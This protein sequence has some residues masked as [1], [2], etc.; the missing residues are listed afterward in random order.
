MVNFLFF[1][2]NPPGRKKEEVFQT[3][4]QIF[5][6]ESLPEKNGAAAN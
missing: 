4:F 2:I 5:H 1:Y 3:Q 6:L